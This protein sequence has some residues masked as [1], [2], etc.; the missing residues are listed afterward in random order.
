MGDNKVFIEGVLTWSFPSK[1][2]LREYIN[3]RCERNW[4]LEVASVWELIEGYKAF[5]PTKSTWLNTPITELITI[6]ENLFRFKF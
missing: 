4:V 2:D 1:S 3:C 6:V 5:E